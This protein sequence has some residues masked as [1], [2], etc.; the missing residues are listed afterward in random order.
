MI[1]LRAAIPHTLGMAQDSR[2]IEP[3]TL[4][5]FRDYLPQAAIAREWLTERACSVYRS[6]GF[7]PIDT[8]ALEYEEILAGKGGQETE[9]QMFRF[10]DPGG[11][12]VA[13]RFDLT[14]PLARFVAQ[15]ANE[16]G[17]PFKRY[18]IA[19]VW[20][21]EKPQKGR[22]REF[23]QCDFDTIG[24]ESACAD[25]ESGLVIVDLM[26]ALGFERFTVHVNDRRV[27]AGLLELL[28]LEQRTAPILRALDKLDKAG[29]RAVAA[30]MVSAGGAS[31][32]QAAQVLALAA[33]EGTNEEVVRA[34][35][36][37]V[38][39]NETGGAGAAALGAFDAAVTAA[40]APAGAFRLRPSL[41]R[42]L[43]Y[44]TGV[45]FETI[46]DELPSIG[47]VCGGGRYDDLAQLF[48]GQRLPGVG[49]SLGVDRLLAAMEE[50]GQM[51]ATRST[52]PVFMPFFAAERLCDYLRLAALLRRGGI[53]VELY[54]EP[55]KLGAQ[56][57]YADRRGF[58]LALI[59][60][61]EEWAAGECQIKD[62]A[63]GES[64]VTPLESPAGGLVVAVERALRAREG[65][66]RK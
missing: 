57:R 7:S 44:Y 40:G 65:R 16:L 9:K 14:V 21:G 41:A 36:G 23:V 54:P 37:L 13:L 34:L 24:T 29:P 43:D 64:T 61:D 51:G 50:L 32:A 22:F 48:T 53:A 58:A 62:L 52:A 28:G 8:P 18:H 6:Y 30:E 35:E 17:L 27:L 38:G 26:L 12:R 56:L 49:A 59:L 31:E 10:E 45:V 66:N 39:A 46:L 47:S 4:K 25:I 1:P 55:R 15:Y 11:R 2:R 3:R 33:V 19:T 60:G 5:G 63:T 20:R 42:G